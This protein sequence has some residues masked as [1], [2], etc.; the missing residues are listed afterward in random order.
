MVFVCNSAHTQDLLPKGW[1]GGQTYQADS[2][3]V[4]VSIVN[5][6]LEERI[7]VLPAPQGRS[8]LA[9]QGRLPRLG[10]FVDA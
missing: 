10:T 8:W 7:V 4:Q 5:L 1:V 9:A 2:A 6:N 3:L